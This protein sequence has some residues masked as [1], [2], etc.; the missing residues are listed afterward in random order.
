MPP[1]DSRH[2]WQ[3]SIYL[4]ACLPSF[5]GAHVCIR[6]C[7][8]M[9]VHVVYMYMEAIHLGGDF[10]FVRVLSQPLTFPRN[11]LMRLG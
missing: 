4:S 1:C 8:V 10:I 3:T 7:V 5:L 6:V 9:H 2:T 11:S